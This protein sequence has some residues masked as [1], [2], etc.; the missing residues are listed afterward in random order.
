MK[1]LLLITAALTIL[2]VSPKLAEAA[3]AVCGSAVQNNLQVLPLDPVDDEGLGD[4]VKVRYKG[5]VYYF[6]RRGDSAIDGHG[7]AAANFIKYMKLCEAQRFMQIMGFS[8]NE[9]PNVIYVKAL[10]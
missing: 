2:S 4:G 7:R 8:W 3:P 9:L 1:Q 10:Y 6:A 5:V